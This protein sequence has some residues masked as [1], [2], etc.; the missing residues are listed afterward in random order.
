MTEYI[1]VIALLSL[2][3]I[4]SGDAIVRILGAFARRIVQIFWYPI[5]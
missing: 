1:L 5:P 4:T 2:V 3:F